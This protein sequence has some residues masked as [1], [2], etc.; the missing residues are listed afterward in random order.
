MR[1]ILLKDIAL[2]YWHLPFNNDP[3]SLLDETLN[4]DKPIDPNGKQLDFVRDGQR[5]LEQLTSSDND[6]LHL[7]HGPE[8]SI[9][10]ITD[11]KGE[12]CAMATTIRR[13]W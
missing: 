11:S 8:G 9:T 5:R 2:L 7:T 1:R 13:S 3:T 10:A 6:W 12:R 4:P